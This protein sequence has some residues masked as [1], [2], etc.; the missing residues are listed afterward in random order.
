M[1]VFACHGYAQASMRMIAEEAGMSVGGLYLYFRNKE[2]LCLTLIRECLNDLAARTAQALQ[3]IT[4]PAEAVRTY[5][6]TTIEYTR[7]HYELI[8]LQGRELGVGFG[9]EMKREYF[10]SRRK[11]LESLIGQ[12]V[13]SGKFRKCDPVAAAGLVVAT[14]RGFAA[15]MMLEEESA[16]TP[17]EFADFVL[18]GLLRRN[19]R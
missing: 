9:I 16:P 12:G 13:E 7:N 3:G 2:E 6:V 14:L 8:L 15:S 19:E 18:H 1:R 17:E 4:D 5:V 10:K 11:L